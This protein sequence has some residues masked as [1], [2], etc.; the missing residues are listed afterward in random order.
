MAGLPKVTLTHTAVAVT[1]ASGAA[2]AANG[3]RSYLLL[4]NISNT[5]M[6]IKLGVAAVASEGIKLAA[7]DAYEMSPRFANLDTRAVNAIHA[8]TGSKTLLVSEG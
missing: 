4:Q 6:F 2:L 5:D 7:G 8:G 1:T 3:E